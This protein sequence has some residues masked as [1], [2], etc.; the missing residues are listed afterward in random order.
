MQ[1]KYVVV[2]QCKYMMDIEYKKGIKD[3]SYKRI[4]A[5]ERYDTIVA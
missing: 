2:R 3:I 5:Q 4:H 1:F